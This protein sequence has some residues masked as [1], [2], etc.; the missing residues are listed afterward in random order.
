MIWL[1]LFVLA[2]ATYFDL[3]S[4]KIPNWLTYSALGLSLFKFDYFTLYMLLLAIASAL[5]F[6]KLVGSGDIKLA[7]VVAIWS[8]ILELSQYWI[9]YSLILGALVGI[10]YRRKSL[11]FAPFITAGVV[12]ANVVPEWLII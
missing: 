1:L 3:K 10:V 2:F 12:I 7:I 8:H 6:G 4:R 5:L 11:P 9:F